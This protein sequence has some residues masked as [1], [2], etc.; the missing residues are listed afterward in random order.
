MNYHISISI[1]FFSFSFQM[2]ISMA[3]K[4]ILGPTKPQNHLTHKKNL[5]CQ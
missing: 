5:Q 2:L 1:K 3:K 4:K